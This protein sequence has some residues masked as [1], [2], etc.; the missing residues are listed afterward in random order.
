MRFGECSLKLLQLVASKGGPEPSLLPFRGRLSL[1]IGAFFVRIGLSLAVIALDAAT[2]IWGLG[3]V[4]YGAI[5]V[6]QVQFA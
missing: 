6:L 5:A 2:R 4:F 1:T 3:A